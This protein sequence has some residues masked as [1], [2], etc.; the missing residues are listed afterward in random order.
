MN[1]KE[2][3]IIDRFLQIRGGHEQT[4]IA[5][6]QHLLKCHLTIITT[7]DV[8]KEDNDHLSC[9]PVLFDRHLSK[10]A[11]RR[12]LR[13]DLSALSSLLGNGMIEKVLVTTCTS[14]ELQLLVNFFEKNSSRTV[15]YVRIFKL[16]D[17]VNLPNETLN[18]VFQLNT[19]NRIHLLFESEE[20]ATA[21]TSV[22]P[23]I[24]T[25]FVLPCNLFLYN[26]PDGEL[27]SDLSDGSLERTFR[28][29]HMGAPRVEKGVENIP[30]IFLWLFLSSSLDN[31]AIV[32]EMRDPSEGLSG[33]KLVLFKFYFLLVITLAKLRKFD[34]RVCFE[35]EI[36]TDV[37]YAEKFYDTD[38]CLIPYCLPAY[39]GR[40]SGVV[41]DAV[42]SRKPFVLTAGMGLQD[43][44][45]FGNAFSCSSNKEFAAM[46]CRVLREPLLFQS[47][48]KA[49]SVLLDRVED[50]K[51]F[52]K[53]LLQ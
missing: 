17:L 45:C 28:I 10:V 38:L 7:D 30:K 47:L 11:K 43:L 35:Q 2:L 27:E 20:L 48:N 5:V 51:R 32:F 40:S 4:Q 26:S 46:I 13:H 37:V 12:A 15:F 39:R 29:T 8:V 3:F 34:F 18:K 50:T 9:K 31:T 44:A 6:L 24:Y 36:S 25:R 53:L 41:L 42:F 22:R 52:L 33:V 14:Y 16:E 23:W 49:R 19:E 1:E 21:A